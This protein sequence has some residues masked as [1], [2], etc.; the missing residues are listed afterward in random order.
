MFHHFSFETHRMDIMYRSDMGLREAINR[1]QAENAQSNGL[2]E[3]LILPHDKGIVTV[4]YDV[5]C[6]AGVQVH[7]ALTRFVEWGCR[8]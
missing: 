2:L 7:A 3:I 1:W 5:L 8:S 6:K 4:L